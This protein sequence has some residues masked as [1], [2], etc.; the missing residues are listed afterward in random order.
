MLSFNH[1]WRTLLTFI[2]QRPITNPNGCRSLLFGEKSAAFSENA[3]PV[4]LST[5][6]CLSSSSLLAILFLIGAIKRRNVGSRLLLS[7][8]STAAPLFHQHLVGLAVRYSRVCGARYANCT[9]I[10][11]WININGSPH[12]KYT[13]C[14]NLR[15]QTLAGVERIS[16]P[17]CC[18]IKQ[19]FR[20]PLRTQTSFHIQLSFV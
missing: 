20:P 8:S 10:T 19:M 1:W 5:T 4:L 9:A 11:Q 13:D 6:T 12:R 15:L 7:E 17:S 14:H 16:V 18:S 3:V 2:Q